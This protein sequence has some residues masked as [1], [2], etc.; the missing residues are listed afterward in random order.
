MNNSNIKLLDYIAEDPNRPIT[1]REAALYLNL[2]LSSI[3]NLI[4]K[5]KLPSYKQGRQLYFL[6]EELR[7]WFLAHPLHK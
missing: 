4:K 5:K 2:S 6:R 3:Y 1:T 7:A